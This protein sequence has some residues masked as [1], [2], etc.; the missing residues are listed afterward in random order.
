ME[1]ARTRDVIVLYKDL[2]I[3]VRLDNGLLQN[4]WP[5]GQGVQWAPSTSDNLVVTA[6]DGIGCAFLLWG[7]DEESDQYVSY[8][9]NQLASTHAI[10]CTG[11]WIISTSSYE[12]YTYESRQLAPL[13]ANTFVT[14]E[15]VYFSLRGLITPQDEWDITADPRAPN[16]YPVGT[17]I[18]PPS[19]SNNFYLMLQTSL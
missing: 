4:G 16:P 8:T 10:A 1:I 9:Q 17:V 3:P 6:S 18:Q 12:S 7:S 5:G 11:T 19:S 14:G 15:Q 13:V 2:T